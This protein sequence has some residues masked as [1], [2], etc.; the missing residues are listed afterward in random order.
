MTNNI[1][2]HNA[3]VSHNERQGRNGHQPCLLWY[4]GLSGSGK[5][6]IANAV[7]RLLFDL[8]CHTYLLDGDNV[9]HGLNQDLGFDDASRVENIRRIAEVSRLMLDAGLIVGTAFIS[10]FISD[11]AQA[12][13]L[14]G[15]AFIEV[16]V[17]TPLSVCE[18]RDPKGLY[19]K[20]RAGEIAHFTGISSPYQAPV[21]ADIHLKTA[22]LSIEQAARQVLAY[23]QWCGVVPARL[24]D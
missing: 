3:A 10:P 18:Q 2:W 19:K 14:A 6:T 1:V 20:A 17:D 7:D 11:R 9:R 5:S 16:F 22:Q 21:A 12:K 8:G 24:A 15:D 23:L 4:T 13:A